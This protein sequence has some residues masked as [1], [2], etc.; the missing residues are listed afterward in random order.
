MTGKNMP[1][2]QEIARYIENIEFRKKAFSGCD[3]EDVMQHISVICTMYE[4]VISKLTE[5]QRTRDEDAREV[6][7]EYKK[8]SDE[9][10]RS[11]SAIDAY[12]SHAMKEA[13]E[14]AEQILKQAREEVKKEEQ[15]IR[16][17]NAKY[18]RELD[19]H[20][21]KTAKLREEGSRFCENARE[22]I[23]QI[24]ELSDDSKQQENE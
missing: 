3:E 22:I 23:K 20:R 6:K 21:K 15:R 17:L 8:K 19:L 7:E 14:E 18:Q 24:E 11:I 12:R 10:I 1:E 4:R 5:E 16:E 9:I 13:E 2:F